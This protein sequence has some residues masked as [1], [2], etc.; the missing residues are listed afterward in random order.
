MR[1][2][3]LFRGAMGCGKSTFIAQHGL[4]RYTLCADKIRMLC[5]SPV[6]SINDGYTISQK[7]D[8]LVWE[9]MFDLLENRMK[10]GE[11]TVIDATNTK[12]SEMSSR[13][14]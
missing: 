8:K 5:Q 1:V 9:I 12:T 13:H 2:L 14:L 10:R 11:F 3:L 6:L 7:N 4:K